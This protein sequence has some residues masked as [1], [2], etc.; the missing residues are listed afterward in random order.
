MPRLACMSARRRV[1]FV[2]V[3]DPAE[4]EIDRHEHQ[5]RAMCHRHRRTR[6]P[7]VSVVSRQPS[8]MAPVD[9]P[10]ETE[11]ED[12]ETGAA[13]DVVLPFDEGD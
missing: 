7:V 6:A 12:Q 1:A 5:S 11:P 9:E 10:E 13:L 3:G 8:R 2:E 4:P